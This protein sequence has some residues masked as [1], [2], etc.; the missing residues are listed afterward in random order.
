M[1][2]PIDQYIRLVRGRSR[3]LAHTF[4][5]EQEDLLARLRP[6]EAGEAL[7]GLGGQLA[8]YELAATSAMRL[9][10]TAIECHYQDAEERALTLLLHS[11]TREILFLGSAAK[12]EDERHL[13]LEKQSD[14]LQQFHRDQGG[15]LRGMLHA[16]AALLAPGL[17]QCILLRLGAEQARDL[18]AQPYWSDITRRHAVA[19]ACAQLASEGKLDE[20]YVVIARELAKIDFPR[21][22]HGEED[23]Y[24]RCALPTFLRRLLVADLVALIADLKC[25]CFADAPPWAIGTRGCAGP[26]Q[27][28]VDRRARATPVPQQTMWTLLP[29]PTQHRLEGTAIVGRHEE[30]CHLCST[31]DGHCDYWQVAFPEGTDFGEA[32]R[33]EDDRSEHAFH[34]T[35]TLPGGTPDGLLISLEYSGVWRPDRPWLLSVVDA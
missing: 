1:T 3:S 27:D 6:G 35:P 13:H 31:H 10:E 32:V 23:R 8:A 21:D 7:P 19:L 16:V 2:T 5:Q 15:V 25:E 33:D 14:E 17:T 30:P 9:E 18:D 26:A 4:Q 28:L 34:F 20:T 29:G 24:L 22:I 12:Q 11:L